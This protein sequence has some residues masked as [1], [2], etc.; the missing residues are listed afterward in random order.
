MRSYVSSLFV[1]C[2]CILC[3]LLLLH[4]LPH[5]LL[6]S[7]SSSSSSFSFFLSSLLLPLLNLRRYAIRHATMLIQAGRVQEGIEVAQRIVEHEDWNV[8]V[9]RFIELRDAVLLWCVC[10]AVLRPSTASSTASSTP[11]TNTA[12]V[13]FL[14]CYLPSRP[15]IL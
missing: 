3:L 8:Q 10:V 5:I 9:N 6:L 14:L 1:I 7:P 4:I 13:S 11:I 2:P 15:I 12:F